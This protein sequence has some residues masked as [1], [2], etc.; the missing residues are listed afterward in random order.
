MYAPP[1]WGSGEKDPHDEGATP[2]PGIAPLTDARCATRAYASGHLAS[3]A[4]SATTT[5]LGC[6]CRMEAWQDGVIGP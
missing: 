1:G 6:S 4:P 5:T 3:A 2:L